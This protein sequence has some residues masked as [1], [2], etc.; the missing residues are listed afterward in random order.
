MSFLFKTLGLWVIWLMLSGG[1]TLVHM[2]L[3]LV[4]SVLVIWLNS[5]RSSSPVQPI[6]LAEIIAYFPWLF[7][8]IVKSSLHLTR[9]ILHPSLPI[10]P[11]MIP[12]RT[13]LRGDVPIVLLGNS[14]TLTPG[15]IT[16]EAKGQ[17]LLVHAMDNLSGQDVINEEFE[18]KIARVFRQ[19][20]TPS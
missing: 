4:L 1:F 11:K 15:T 9:L 18:R 19:E 10:A 12:Y 6:P 13:R 8:R 17:E 20:S 3:G 5:G 2:G 14:I 16:V 7:V